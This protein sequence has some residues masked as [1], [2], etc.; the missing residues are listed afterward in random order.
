MRDTQ[1][2]LSTLSLKCQK[3]EVEKAKLTATVDQLQQEKLQL[4]ESIGKK[5]AEI[6]N[7]K[8]ASF[9]SFIDQTIIDY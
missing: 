1:N 6:S 9:I 4:N 8:L 3:Q 5:Q 7:M 2:E